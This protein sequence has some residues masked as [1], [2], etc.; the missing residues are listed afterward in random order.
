MLVSVND[1]SP[2]P[3]ILPLA[4]ALTTFPLTV[5]PRGKAGLPW[6]LTGCADSEKGL[7]S[8]AILRTQRLAR[9][10]GERSS[11]GHYDGLGLGFLHGR[12]RRSHCGSYFLGYDRIRVN[13]GLV[14]HASVSRFFMGN[15]F[16]LLLG[17]GSPNFAI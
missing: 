14:V 5:A 1:S 12:G 16:Q 2:W 11:G 8:L 9:G 15:L 17:C 4:L 3:F 13:S 10:Y 7:S 6:T